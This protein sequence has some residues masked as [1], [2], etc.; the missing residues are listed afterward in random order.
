[1][2]NNPHLKTLIEAAVYGVSEQVKQIAKEQG[3]E[4]EI[5]SSKQT[6][7]SF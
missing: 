1:M 4:V 3:I 2:T 5:K 6:L 7:S